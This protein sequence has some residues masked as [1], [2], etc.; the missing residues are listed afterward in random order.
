MIG[1]NKMHYRNLAKLTL[2]SV[3]LLGA[4]ACNK[5]STKVSNAGA[6]NPRT[7]KTGAALDFT[8]RMAGPISPN[9]NGTV[10]L[11][12]AHDYSGETLALSATADS[13]IR[14]GAKSTNIALVKDRA[15]TW[16]IPFTTTANG[17]YYINVM[18]TVKDSGGQ[19]QFRAYAVRVE[20]G[21]QTKSNKPAP[22]EVILPADEKI[23]K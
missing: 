3:V 9:S 1:V 12:I 10:T 14:L 18:G 5:Q 20:V 4:S 2:L 15:A 13:A 6:V 22:K 21:E 7:V 19:A 11:E 8:H 23:S 16:T 17:A